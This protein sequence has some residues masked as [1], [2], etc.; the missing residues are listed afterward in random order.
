MRTLLSF[1]LA[2]LLAQQATF[3]STVE[4]VQVDVVVIDK[5]GNTV[6]GLTAADFN[7]TDRKKAQT[8]ASFDEASYKRESTAAPAV[9]MPPDV[10]P[11]VIDN[12]STPGRLVVMV[13]DDL[14]SFK[15]RDAKVK[16]IAT[17]IVNELGPN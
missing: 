9:P 5:N 15:G 3:K 13:L 7:L 10:M 11:D 6:R 1:T 4:L 17:K 14:H 12:Q 8:I 2:G 16:E